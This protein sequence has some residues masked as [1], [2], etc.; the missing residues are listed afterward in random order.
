MSHVTK[1]RHAHQVTAASLHTLLH[2]PHTEYNTS[3][4]EVES[5]LSFEQ[6]CQVGAQQSVVQFDY[7][8]K[9]LSLELSMLLFIWCIHEGNFQLY[10]ESLTAIVPW[11]FALD[12]NHYSRWLSVHIRDMVSLKEKHAA[13]FTE[14]CAGKF[15]VNKIGNKFSAM[16]LN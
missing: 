9:T 1:T 3:A 5:A 16:A 6:W 12:H 13:S 15:S 8:L 2:L 7:W 10:M 14:F 11:M 4:T